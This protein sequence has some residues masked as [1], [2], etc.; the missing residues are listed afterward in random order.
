MSSVTKIA[1]GIILSASA[2]SASAV[3]I[4]KD[5]EVGMYGNLGYK[6]Y[7]NQD[8]DSYFTSNNFYTQLKFGKLK[9]KLDVNG[10]FDQIN[11]QNE[12]SQDIENYDLYQ[13]YVSY[14]FN[15]SNKFKV[16]RMSSLNFKGEDSLN[17]K[18]SMIDSTNP[19]NI[20]GNSNYQHID[21][22]SYTH[23]MALNKGQ[24]EVTLYGGENYMRGLG[25]NS[26][27]GDK[28]TGLLSFYKNGHRFLTGMDRGSFT[29]SDDNIMTDLDITV[30]D[31][32]YE[33]IYFTY[34]FENKTFFTDNTY[35]ISNYDDNAIV[36]DRKII[37]TKIGTK[38]N[39]FKPFFGFHQLEVEQSVIKT[40]TYGI[41]YDYKK[42]G[43]ILSKSEVSGDYYDY[44]TIDGLSPSTTPLE[45]LDEEIYSA[46][47]IYNF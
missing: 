8:L 27:E 11:L 20:F 29:D 19:V 5:I 30:D 18:E 4:S 41:R 25:E 34:Q 37:D 12:E 47:I 39:R 3:E 38:V 45:D 1:L 13:G 14:E 26:Y 42:F 2:L 33:N 6:D 36:K 28:F 35:V 44:A 23:T 32:E 43:F 46:Q 7:K 21:G 24:F 31:L 10:Q 16:G 9:V 40:I 22:A 17:I 15:R